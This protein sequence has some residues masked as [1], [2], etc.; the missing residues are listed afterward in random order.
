MF[1]FSQTG[2]IRINH[3]NRNPPTIQSVWRVSQI[4]SIRQMKSA[5]IRITNTTL[6]SK[7]RENLF[8][9][10]I[11]F[12]N[13][14]S[15]ASGRNSVVLSIANTLGIPYDNRTLAK[16]SVMPMKGWKRMS[17]ENERFVEASFNP[18]IIEDSIWNISC[19]RWVRWS[20]MA[21]NLQFR[22]L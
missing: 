21:S 1:Y 11:S 13:L 18:W 20:P 3:K 10:K 22:V 9:L 12:I 6:D 17:L 14:K 15:L 16:V 8:V 2:P 4:P 5:E 7:S 19:F